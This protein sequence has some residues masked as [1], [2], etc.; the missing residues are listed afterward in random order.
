MPQS[1][2]VGED[3]VEFSVKKVSLL[4]VVGYFFR[5]FRVHA[6]TFKLVD[7]FVLIEVFEV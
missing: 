4:N 7:N 5:M 3:L 6:D 2:L 1:G